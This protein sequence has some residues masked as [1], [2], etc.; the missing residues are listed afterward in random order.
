MLDLLDPADEQQRSNR[1]K[2]SLT[3]LACTNRV[4]NIQSKR[5]D[6]GSE[7]EPPSR[8]Q[9]RFRSAVHRQ[10]PGAHEQAELGPVQRREAQPD[11]LIIVV[12]N[13]LTLDEDPITASRA[14]TRGRTSPR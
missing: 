3:L 1:I 6:A 12:T 8:P 14:S 11:M 4:G 2:P 10:M 13:L 9:H 7:E 5:R